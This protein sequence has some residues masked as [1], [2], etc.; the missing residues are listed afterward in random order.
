MK[1]VCRLAK[2]GPLPEIQ[3]FICTPCA[4]VTVKELGPPVRAG[5]RDYPDTAVADSLTP[6]ATAWAAAQT[7]PAD[8]GTRR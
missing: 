2:V 4:D 5:T 1:L 8:D 6:T 7:I 3:V